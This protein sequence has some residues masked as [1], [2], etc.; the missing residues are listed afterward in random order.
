MTLYLLYEPI[1]VRPSLTLPVTP[2]QPSLDVADDP[3]FMKLMTM[4]TMEKM[5]G[6]GCDGRMSADQQLVDGR[7]H[8][9]N[10]KVHLLLAK[11]KIC[12]RVLRLQMSTNLTPPSLP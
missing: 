9:H 4:T 8:G 11:F 12:T 2:T 1:P 7:R 5:R 10:W 6:A 3:I